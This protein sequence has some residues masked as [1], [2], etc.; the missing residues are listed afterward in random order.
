MKKMLSIML[1]VILILGM[2]SPVAAQAAQPQMPETGIT[3]NEFGLGKEKVN[4]TAGAAY[5][6]FE[7]SNFGIQSFSAPPG[8]S[9]IRPSGSVV[10]VW[11]TPA[12]AFS[13]GPE[14]G[15]RLHHQ[16]SPTAN[17]N[18]RQFLIPQVNFFFT[19]NPGYVL[20]YVFDGQRRQ[21]GSHT[22]LFSSGQTLVYYFRR[23][24]DPTFNLTVQTAIN[25]SP[26]HTVNMGSFSS[27]NNV[28][29]SPNTSTGFDWANNDYVFTGWTR[30]SGAGNFQNANNETTIFTTGAATTTIRANFTRV[31]RPQ[32]QTLTVQTF[33]NGAMVYSDLRGS[34]MQGN[35]IPI[36]PN[37]SGFD[38]ANYNYT[39][40]GWIV[41]SGDGTIVAPG[42]GVQTTN[43]SMGSSTAVVRA[44]F[45]RTPNLTPRNLHIQTYVVGRGILHSV[46][47]GMH[48][49]GTL[50]T[51]SADETNFDTAN[52][53]YTFTG[54]ITIPA[55]IGN[56]ITPLLTTTNFIT[57]NTDTILRAVY[58]REPI[59]HPTLI[60]ETYVTGQ[61]V[62]NTDA[63]GNTHLPGTT[64]S[65]SSDESGFDTTNYTYTFTGWVIESGIGTIMT[66]GS[67]T[68]NFITGTVDTT[69][70]AVY[71]RVSRR[72]L[73]VQTYVASTG[74]V[75]DITTFDIPVSQVVSIIPNTSS[76]A[77]ATHIY[78]FS[79]WELISG[80]GSFLNP[81]DE[82]TAFTTG[83]V[84]TIV[85]AVYT[86]RLRASISLT[87]V[88]WI[89]GMDIHTVTT[90]EL[91]NNLVSVSP[92]TASFTIPGFDL[93]FDG[94]TVLV[95]GGGSIEAPG[96]T[97][98]NTNFRMGNSAATLHA[99][100]IPVPSTPHNLTIQTVVGAAI[101]HTNDM[102]DFPVNSNVNISPNTLA[103]DTD[104]YTYTF[105]GWTRDSG[106]G[107]FEAP[108]A[109]SQNTVFRTGAA[110]TVLSA[111]FT[112][113]PRLYNLTVQTSVNGSTVDT[114]VLSS[115]PAGQVVN[116]SPN[117]A[118]FNIAQYTYTFT[119]WVVVS[120]SGAFE[121]PGVNVEST[122]FRAGNTDTVIRA[123]FTRTLITTPTPTP[124]PVPRTV[125]VQTMVNG[126][127]A[128]EEVIT[129]LTTGQVISVSPNTSGFNMAVR[130]YDF[131]N[132]IIAG[133]AGS[134]SNPTVQ[135]T[136]FTVGAG[137]AVL[138]VRFLTSP[139]ITTPT[140]TPTPPPTGHTVTIQTLVNG[141]IVHEEVITGLA[142]G[143]V[144]SISPNTS[145]FNTVVNDYNFTNWLRFSGTG[146]ISN[147]NSQTANFTVGTSDAVM[148]ARFT[149]TPVQP[150]FNLTVQTV[151]DGVVVYTNN[152]GS[153]LP[154]TVVPVSA[155]PAVFDTANF[156]YT[157]INWNRLFGSGNISSNSNP[158]PNYTTGTSDTTIRI[159]FT[160]A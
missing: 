24:P 58:T 129:G 32:P 137:N 72:N 36:W 84:N 124:V 105:T 159:N 33:V 73:T 153:F 47:S 134:I 143:Q 114:Q 60:I 17:T 41:I 104:Y 9:T 121:S 34:F 38:W 27:N 66:P 91:E 62:V 45:T 100:F 8:W 101:V 116:V 110:P 136:S 70:R 54:W 108:G 61:G 106:L 109:T 63:P 97:V 88:T 155:N 2:A 69:V 141:G 89:N 95:A 18:N 86:R 59:P 46:F 80:S 81:N 3:A 10:T 158:T 131:N 21:P 152:L 51:A 92:N 103:L 39:F 118:G 7:A 138:R 111:N 12:T 42:A 19:L 35:I 16:V 79:H 48:P 148:R 90:T 93:I 146:S 25:N 44:N 96:P 30:V 151:V 29:V 119:G 157:F 99:N 43:F 1:C 75:H 150:R 77:T 40:N 49:P 139:I 149:T 123:Q 126:A 11:G 53:V 31:P 68:T 6:S 15:N 128:H 133:G 87:I 50:I 83:A 132:W 107:T 57:G 122:N 85:R 112:R 156:T 37:V 82:T 94:W 76:F 144:I 4:I 98:E 130:N 74:V 115:T 52:Y 65:A 120:G 127:V 78:T 147:S 154:G 13:S 14:W 28:T 64:V 5:A 71:T 23:I 140:P 102:G 56:I 135:T 142:T 26:V 55:G 113:T 145:G 117:T 67:I 22:L 20:D 160:R 125:T